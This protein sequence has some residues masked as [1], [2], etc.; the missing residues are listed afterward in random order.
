MEYKNRYNDVFTFTKDDDNN[1]LW[2]GNF[3]WCR[4]AWPN[5]YGPAY[6]QYLK[7]EPSPMSFED[8]Q[9]AVHKEG[10]EKYQ[11]LIKSDLTRIHMVD[12]SGGPYMEE[13]MHLGKWLGEEF[14]NLIIDGFESID[15]GF[16]IIT[17]K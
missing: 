12:P 5:D 3:R 11:A 9:D 6:E 4:M 8:F 15:T 17:K 16:K 13:G 2:E 10:L 14:E 1:V 7:D